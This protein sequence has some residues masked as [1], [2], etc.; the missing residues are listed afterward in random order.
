MISGFIGATFI[1]ELRTL[2]SKFPAEIRHLQKREAAVRI[3]EPSDRTGAGKGVKRTFSTNTCLSKT[4]DQYFVDRAFA[5]ELGE[6]IRAKSGIFLVH[7]PRS[8]GKTTMLR[9]LANYV[10]SDIYVYAWVDAFGPSYVA[11]TVTD[12]SV[13]MMQKLSVPSP[14]RASPEVQKA[15]AEYVSTYRNSVGTDSVIDDCFQFL[16]SR[17]YG[18]PENLQK[19]IFLIGEFDAVH[20]KPLSVGLA[21]AL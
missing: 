7:G 15:A 5:V 4:C 19:L 18:S 16:F 2:S 9:Q 14:S 3:A 1:L 20:S 21:A 17:R 11:Q 6:E 13:L 8:S 10:V 12:F